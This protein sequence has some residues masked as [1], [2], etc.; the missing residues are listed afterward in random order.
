[1]SAFMLTGAVM[2]IPAHAAT[3][4]E[5][6]G[7]LPYWRKAT[8]TADALLHLDTFKEINP[9]GYSVKTD[10]TIA[11]TAKMDEDPWPALIAAAKAK[12]IRVVPTIMWSNGAAIHAVLSDGPSRRKLEDDIAALVKEKGYDGIDID[13]EGKRA[14][15]KQY[16]AT[17]LKGLAM[18]MTDKWIMCDIEPRTPVDSRYDGTPPPDATEYANDYVAIGK[19]CD[20]V[21]IMAY[22]QGA[23]DVRLNRAAAGKP[24]IPVADPL[25]VEK[26]V[27]LTAQSIPKR[28]LVLGV[29]TYGY[30]YEVTPL[31]EQG[32]RYDLLWAFNQ[33]Y[34]FDLMAQYHPSVQ[35]NSAGELSFSYIPNVFPDAQPP[36]T[37]SASLTN[38]GILPTA[39]G[40]ASGT[41]A[42]PAF[43][44][45][46]WSDANAIKDKVAL[47]KK[48]GLRGVAIFKID[49]G[50]DPAL[51]DILK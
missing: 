43:N 10:G 9:F 44:I 19:Y 33:K 42:G 45:L 20:R 32:Y 4:L 7:W 29:P 21:R 24:Y 3:T 5:I 13:F 12:K 48:L 36:G 31:S 2:G 35:R 37:E 22:D 34:A 14:E 1:M 51:W 38:N 8:S 50:E 11:D 18:R 16:F 28:K 40:V 26:V 27:K 47:A 6:S 23:I 30:E 25:W 41:R 15:T 17:F 39:S 49:G 46:W